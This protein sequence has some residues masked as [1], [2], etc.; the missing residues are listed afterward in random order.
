MA[1]GYF[2]LWF[3]NLL[4][5]GTRVVFTAD[6]MKILGIDHAD[7]TPNLTTDDFLDDLLSVARVPALGSAFT[8]GTKTV[9]TIAAGVFDAAD[10][11]PAFTALTGD[12]FESLV[13]LKDTG[14]ESTSNLI[15]KWDTATGL[16][17]TPN[18]G[19]VN[20]TFNAGGILVLSG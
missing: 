3:N 9:G 19:D 15:H 10:G 1:N 16:P 7:D 5:T 17:F 12:Q 18:G 11:A 6:S 4:G 13:L 14:T 2:T 20:I 8:L